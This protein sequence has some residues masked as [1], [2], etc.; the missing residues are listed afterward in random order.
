MV[1]GRSSG[2]RK[3]IFSFSGNSPASRLIEENVWGKGMSN[4]KNVIWNYVVGILAMVKKRNCCTYPSHVAWGGKVTLRFRPGDVESRRGATPPGWELA[5]NHG[6]DRR[7]L[8]LPQPCWQQQTSRD[9]SCPPSHRA[10]TCGSPSPPSPPPPTT[11]TRSPPPAPACACK[12][13]LL[14][15]QEHHK[16]SQPF[17]V[18]HT[19]MW[20]NF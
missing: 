6:V 10:S 13:R 18:P 9:C 11:S 4:P 8:A 17:W 2:C 16:G 15:G 20:Q 19:L 7:V 3:C 5:T 14:L 12:F 1:R